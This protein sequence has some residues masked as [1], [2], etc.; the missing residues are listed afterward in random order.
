LGATARMQRGADFQQRGR[1]LQLGR[2]AV[3]RRARAKLTHCRV[4]L[5]GERVGGVVDA[6][7]L[8]AEGHRKVRRDGGEGERVQNNTFEISN[9][10]RGAREVGEL[11]LP[12]GV[13]V[14]DGC[15]RRAQAR[16][17]HRGRGRGVARTG[18]SSGARPGS[19]PT[20]PWSCAG[21]AR[22]SLPGWRRRRCGGEDLL[23]QKNGSV[24]QWRPLVG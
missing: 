9:L 21:T 20:C 17:R 12:A 7:E 14:R 22:R 6:G 23:H 10:F 1:R 18:T 15:V 11:L 4:G 8:H 19:A 24:C 2:V 5:A 13:C 3:G 16:R